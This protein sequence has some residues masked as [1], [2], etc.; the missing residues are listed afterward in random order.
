M[1]NLSNAGHR[2]RLRTRYLKA[3][4]DGFPDYD[5]V[6]LLLTYCIQRRDVKPIARELLKRFKDIGGIM[7]AELQELCEAEG[8]G[9]NSALLF[10]LLRDLCVRYLE[11]QVK[12][13]D[14]I[15][16]P[17][18]LQNYARMKL[19]EFPDEVMML[20]CLNTKNHVIHS[21]IISRGTIDYA[22]IYPRNVAA[23]ALRK[24]AAGV[25]IIHNHPSGVT[26]PSKADKKFTEDVRFALKSLEIRLLDHLIVSRTDAFSFVDHGL[27]N[28]E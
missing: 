3:G 15:S 2:E 27:L 5:M 26:L 28:M 16:S 4:G 13:T 21:E 19:S 17:D 8:M 9:E 20:I 14:V 1:D 23:D 12:N 11:C 6:E 18:Q 25:I 24:K 10:K 22:V 7:D